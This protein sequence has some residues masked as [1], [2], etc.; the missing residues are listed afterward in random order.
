MNTERQLIFGRLGK[1]PELKYTRQQEPICRF[2]VAENSKDKE[3]TEWHNIVVW[4]KQA[5]HC[6]MY[7]KKGS[8]VFVQ[9][10]KISK[11]YTNK[12]NEQKHFIEFKADFVGFT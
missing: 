2:T 10:Q 8:P 6:N 5:E 4:G 12:L 11:E 3:T 9:G 1:N 7:L